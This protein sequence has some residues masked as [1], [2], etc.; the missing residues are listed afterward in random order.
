MPSQREN[1]ILF[2]NSSHIIRPQDDVLKKYLEI[3]KKMTRFCKKVKI[4]MDHF[5]LLLWYLEAG[6]I[7]K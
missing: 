6:E 5:D 7:F 3:E 4:P 1:D 2:I